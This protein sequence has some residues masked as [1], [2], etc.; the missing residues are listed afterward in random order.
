M[1]RKPKFKSRFRVET[2]EEE[3]V[4]LL[5]ER[6]AIILRD[7]LYQLLVPLLDKNL[8]TDEI[9]EQLQ[10]KLP[11]PY[12]Y[13][14]LMELKQKGYLIEN[15]EVLPANIAVFCEHLNVNLENA[16]HRLQTTKVAVK[17]L[18]T[19]FALEFIATL[20]SLQIQVAEE[21]DLE[22]VLT[23]DYLRTELVEIN[24]KNLARSRPWM[25]V[26]PTGT[27]I[28]I[29]PVF[30]PHKTGCWECLSQRLQGN[31]PVEGFIQRRK[32]YALPLTPPLANL[33]STLQT[34]LSM[35]A[36]EI[37][38]WI[39]QG[40]NK[41]LKGVLVTH[42]TLALETQNHTLIR[43]PQ[44]P[45]CGIIKQ[46]HRQPLPV[47][48]GSRKKTFTADGGHRCL[49]PEATFEKYQQHISPITG[50]VREFGKLS[51]NLNGLTPTYFAKHHFASMFDDL[52]V[53]E[54][55]IG[56]RSA[57]KG[58][59]DAQARASG[60]CEAIERYSGVFQGDEIRVKN[61]YQKMADKA[62]HPNICMNFSQAQYDNRE[63]WNAYCAS[64]F[65]RVP[66]PFNEE[67]EIEWTPVW[68]VTH[69]CFKYLPTAYCYF[70][71]PL[72]SE[73]NCWADTN[74]CAAGN[75]LEEATVQGFMELVERDSV[76]L[77]W[78][79]RI[80][81]PGVDLESFNEPYF[82]A[83]KSYYQSIHRELWVLDITSDLNIPTFTAISRR[84]DVKVEDIILG[85]GT[86]FDPKLAIQRALTE[87]NQILPAVL[88]SHADGTTQY[89]ASA[90]PP[91]LDWWKTATLE[92]QPYLAPDNNIAPKVHSNYPQIE[93]ND[94]LDDIKLCQQI[95][96]QR[97]ME[98]L[99]LNQTRPDIGLKVVKVIV[100]GMR[101]F[102][103]RLG[104]GRL[105]EVPVQLGWLKEPIPEEQLNPFPM[106]M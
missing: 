61:S 67:R 46:E 20:E 33:P 31:R 4:F 38:K 9:A 27:I 7:R 104:A 26:K 19:P 34:A 83:L 52:S 22:V 8:T 32:N 62:I 92:N 37:L 99:I 98:M 60:F 5:S 86:H 48:F 56:G 14:A 13:Y 57:G 63:K 66:E 82:Q 94:L 72:S 24:Q 54:Q 42:D 105:Y 55:N 1:F 102:W 95:I 43:R 45:V 50:I 68:S 59:T 70:G 88:A 39:I 44:C 18:G 85:F 101:H 41:R 25:L 28:W 73:P 74:G 40:E 3:G 10:D 91:V 15:E 30:H 71:Y 53:L 2:V 78:Y 77:W 21:A 6:G 36:T 87:M 103:K 100:P 47:V 79:N 106:W 89:A 84:N 16:R 97:G 80:S 11:A 76:A 75:T 51:R 65:Q 93:H 12:I 35:A 29:G 17:A 96:Q 81:R 90:E 69:Q 64:F 58:R 49:E 23:D